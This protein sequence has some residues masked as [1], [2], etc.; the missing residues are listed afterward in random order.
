MARISHFK[1]CS[2]PP[3]KAIEQQ[4]TIDHDREI[5]SDSRYSVSIWLGYANTIQIGE[6]SLYWCIEAQLSVIRRDDF[7]KGF[8][9]QFSIASISPNPFLSIER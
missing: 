6:T 9:L 8:R 3:P 2:T 7:G 4:A 1:R 5:D